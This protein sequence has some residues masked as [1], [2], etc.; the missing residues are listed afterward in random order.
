MKLSM[1]ER[2]TYFSPWINPANPDGIDYPHFS[3]I[4]Q[5]YLLNYSKSSSLYNL[6]CCPRLL[7]P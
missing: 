1:K 4:I 7:R 5:Q 6:N 3:P 2:P